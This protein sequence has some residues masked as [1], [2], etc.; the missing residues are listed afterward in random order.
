M[1]LPYYWVIQT[2]SLENHSET[3]RFNGYDIIHLFGDITVYRPL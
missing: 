2:H 3:V 1:I